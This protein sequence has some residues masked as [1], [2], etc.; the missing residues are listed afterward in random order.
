MDM[1]WLAKA[2]NDLECQNGTKKFVVSNYG[3]RIGPDEYISF[4]AAMR[5]LRTK[6]DIID[7]N[8]SEWKARIW[9]F[10]QMHMEEIRE[11]LNGL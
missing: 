8:L 5:I 6:I 3:I 1:E 4:E 10:W 11:E 9:M 7:E 2:L